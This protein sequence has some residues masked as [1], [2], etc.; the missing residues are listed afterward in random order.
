MLTY[1]DDLDLSIFTEDEMDDLWENRSHAICERLL[2]EEKY[3]KRLIKLA[4]V[5]SYMQYKVLSQRT[6]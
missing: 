4:Q 1:P 5:S 6:E 3:K 2:G